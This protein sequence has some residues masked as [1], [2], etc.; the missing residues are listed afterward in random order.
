MRNLIVV[1]FVGMICFAGAEAEAQ[2]PFRRIFEPPTRDDLPKGPQTASNIAR[3]EADQAYQQGD[4]QR[5]L[6][7]TNQLLLGNPGD[8]VAY[9]LRASAKIELGRSSGSTARVREGIADARQALAIAGNKYVWLYVPYF[10]GLT[11]LSELERRPEHAD[12]AIS[13]ANPVLARSNIE[14]SDRAQLL[15]QRA[16]AH[17]IKKDLKAEV[18][19]YDEAIRLSPDLFGAYIKRAQAYAAAGQIKDALTSCD[20]TV[21]AFPNNAQAYND[22]GTYRRTA[23]DLD[24]AILDLTRALQIEPGLFVAYISR[25]ICLS[26]QNSPQA[27]EVDFNDALKHDLGFYKPLVYRLRATARFAQGTIDPAIEDYSTAV[28]L[29]PQDPALYEERGFAQFAKKQYLAAAGDFQKARQLN[30][31]LTRLIPWQFLALSHAGQA[32]EARTLL[33]GFLKEKPAVTGWVGVVCSYLAGQIAEAELLEA[34]KDANQ[35]VQNEKL[36][37]VHFFLGGKKT[38]DRTPD[39]AEHYRQSVATRMFLLATYRAARHE[40]GDLK[41]P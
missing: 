26:E 39:A 20:A 10:Y 34:A 40:L 16:L 18:Q 36:C 32:D 15:Y 11:A 22:R 28:K 37:E 3:R 41:T 2:F 30:P 17:A 29:S 27:A 25:G 9:H 38:L 19:D 21:R 5:V 7:V 1:V 13:I 6:N 4:Y 33:D 35:R 14:A 12:M 23:G 8:H 31:Q 24:G